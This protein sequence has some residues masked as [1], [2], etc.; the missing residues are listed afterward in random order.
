MKKRK[1]RKLTENELIA[2]KVMN[3]LGMTPNA[4]A[5]EMGRDP[6]TVRKYLASNIYTINQCIKDMVDRVKELYI[7]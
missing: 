7:N 2:F 6:K 4:I 3:D 5:V 1:K